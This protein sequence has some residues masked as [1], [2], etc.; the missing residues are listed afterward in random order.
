LKY[1]KNDILGLYEVMEEFN[2]LTFIHFNQQITDALTITRL[3]LN[4]FYRYY[5]LP[6]IKPIPYIKKTYI[7]NFIKEAYFGGIT[8]VYRPYGENLILIDV[9]SLY[10]H[11]ALNDMTGIDC[12]YMETLD[13]ETTLNLDEIFGFFQAKIETNN[14]YIGLL[15]IRL[16]NK[17]IL[18]NGKF[19]GI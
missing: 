13:H 7:F 2:R 3:S 10:P 14:N 12:R 5:Y 11:S 18:P 6:S 15:P 9:N 17:I 1:L 16:K 19:E 8:E 4:I